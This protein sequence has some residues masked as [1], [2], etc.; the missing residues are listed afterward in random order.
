MTASVTEAAAVNPEGTKTLLA[1]GVSKFFINGKP[2]VINGL[3]KLRNLPFRLLIILVVSF[4]KI[5]LF[6][7]DLITL[8]II[9]TTVS[10]EV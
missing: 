10:A 3:R 9:S 5:P 7:K 8:P 6:S 4:K 1:N 2:V